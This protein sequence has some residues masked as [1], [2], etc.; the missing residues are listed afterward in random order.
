MKKGKSHPKGGLFI[1]KVPPA[2]SKKTLEA[3]FSKFGK[4]ASLV[5]PYDAKKKQHNGHLYLHYDNVIAAEEVASA[6]HKVTSFE[7]KF[8]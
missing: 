7:S 4:I 6:D 2:L 5:M 1:S 3:Y 8:C